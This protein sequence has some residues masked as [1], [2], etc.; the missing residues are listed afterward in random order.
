M[1]DVEIK[2]IVSINTD[3]ENLKD[4]IP[5]GHKLV[6]FARADGKLELTFIKNRISDWIIN[7]LDGQKDG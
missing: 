3:S 6:G 4:F 2:V 7:P 1:S 5:D